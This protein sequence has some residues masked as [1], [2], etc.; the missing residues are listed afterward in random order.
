RL[1]VLGLLEAEGERWD[2]VWILGM[3]DDVLPA[4]PSPNPLLP[5]S[6]LAQANAPRATAARELAYA[7]DLFDALLHCAP[8]VIVSHAL[9]EGERELRPS[10]LIALLP[11]MAAPDTEQRPAWVDSP[12]Q[13]DLFAE[14]ACPA[15][16]TSMDWAGTADSPAATPQAVSERVVLEPLS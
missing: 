1:D 7:H 4:P 15:G 10:P 11:A 3:T 13:I 16:E 5:A 8:T 2:G 9:L 6:A 12:V 14:E